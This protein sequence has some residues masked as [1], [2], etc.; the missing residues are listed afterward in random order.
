MV[1]TIQR[2]EII[3]RPLSYA[4]RL[5]PRA[6]SDIRRAVIHATELPDLETAREYGERIQHPQSAT[7]NSGHFYIDRDGSIEQW[8]AL[9]RVAHHVANHNLDSVGIELSNRGRCPDW[10]D[11]RHQHWPEPYDDR[12]LAALITL[13]CHLRRCLPRLQG[14]IG[15]DQLDKRMVPASDDP[16]KTVRRRT[17][18]GPHFPWQ[19]ISEATGLGCLKP[20][21][22]DE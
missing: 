8:V 9:E 7:G 11:T 18:P 15:H 17:D 2:P 14:I 19:Q 3:Q 5:A 6:L 22:D 10:F 12:Q 13:L 4:E 16:A 20:D 21:P 1:E